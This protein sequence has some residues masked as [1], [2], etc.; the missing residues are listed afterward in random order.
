MSQRLQA[1]P[2]DALDQLVRLHTALSP[3][4]LTGDGE[5]PE[6]V[7]RE[8]KVE[9]DGQLIGFQMSHGL[10]QDDIGE[11]SV[12]AEFDRRQDLARRGLTRRA[13]P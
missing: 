2:D 10:S 5:I 7:W 3:E 4:A 8:R 6:S 1:L 9:L 13:R 12:Y 11:D